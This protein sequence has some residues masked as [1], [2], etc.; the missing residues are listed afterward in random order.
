MRVHKFGGAS[1]NSP[2]RRRKISTIISSFPKEESSVIIF[3][4]IGKTTNK[5]E[6]VVKAFMNGE[7]DEALRIFQEIK[8][9]HIA[10]TGELTSNHKQDACEKLREVF[11]EVEWLLHDNPVRPF[12]YYYDQVVSSG[13]LLSSVI[14]HHLV[15]MAGV[16]AQF[17][18]ARDVIRT[19]ANF[20]EGNIDMAV[21]SEK[22]AAIVKPQIEKNAVIITQGFIGSTSDNEN[23][24]L[25]REG[26]DYTSAI[27]ANTCGA[28]SLTIWK[29][30]EAVMSADP[31]LYP[32][33]TILPELSFSEVI[34]MAYYGAQV[35]HPKTIKPLQNKG[36]PLYV[37]SFIDPSKPGTLISAT[38]EKKLPP[39]IVIKQNQVLMQFKSI[40]FSFVSGRLS[41]MLSEEFT[42]LNFYPNLTQ[43]TAISLICCVD[44]RQDK[45][46]KMAS[47]A[48]T[49][50]DVNVLKGVKLLTIRHHNEDIINELIQPEKT[51][52]MQ[53]TP[54]TVQ[55]IVYS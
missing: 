10:F 44:D 52:L 4:A 7:K 9:D 29:D 46:E 50:F 3:S 8:D 54:E 17:L 14:M 43:N 27:F 47:V 51:L 11:V 34:E 41:E 39:I 6:E 25:G 13:E 28:E 1:T 35:I 55:A 42:S 22:M 53:R 16:D 38:G 31:R 15:R 19:D 32:S 5:L 20:R 37:K 26:S 12:D 2:E 18:D 23:T 24:T 36:I 45:I 49:Y 30:V 21:T 48:S 33:A 40:D